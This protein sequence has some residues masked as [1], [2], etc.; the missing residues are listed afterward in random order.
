MWVG[1]QIEGEGKGENLGM[2]R[3]GGGGGRT[4]GCLGM[5]GEG[6]GWERNLVMH[7]GIQGYNSLS[8][9]PGQRI[10][11]LVVRVAMSVR[12]RGSDIDVHWVPGHAGV[13]GNDQADQHAKAAANPTFPGRDGPTGNGDFVSLAFLK[14]RR[15]AKATEEWRSG[16]TTRS[17]GKKVFRNPR[18]GARPRI[19]A[20]LGRVPK[21]AESRF[22]QLECGHAMLAPLLKDKLGWIT[23][24]LCWW[25]DSETDQG[26]SVQG[27]QGVEERDNNVMERGRGDK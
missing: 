20:E 3:N 12:A 18:T 2:L 10:A 4:W 21:E 23:P 15:T 16:I 6:A 26:T 5:G 17:R 22:Y 24:D 14:T 9:G 11:S 8:P 25:W 27:V 7:K 13:E 19:R 1:M